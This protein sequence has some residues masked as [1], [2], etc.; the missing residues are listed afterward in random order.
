MH[1]CKRGAAAV[2]AVA[3]ISFALGAADPDASAA[4]AASGM[5]RA[6]HFSPDTPGV[7]IYLTPF[8]GGSSGLWLPNVGYGAVSDYRAVAA[9]L[10]VVAM[11]AH[12]AAASTPPIVSW[13][14]NVKSGKAYT[15]AAIGSNRALK[16]VVLNDDLS[17]PSGGT[18]RVRVIQAASRA[19]KADIGAASGQSI[20]RNVA[21]G[22][23]TGYVSL[24]AGTWILRA[25]A[26]GGSGFTASGQVSIA[27]GSVTSILLVDAP[28]GGIAVRSVLDAAGTGTVPV[29]AVPAGYGGTAAGHA[30]PRSASSGAVGALAIGL[31]ALLLVT[32]GTP[33]R[34]R[35]GRHHRA[36]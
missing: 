29:G 33:R 31:A 2:V 21:F 11:R 12:G 32:T 3:L 26:L 28:P 7:D 36:T 18:G 34:P 23:T 27:S 8:S 5:I 1:R 22:S 13:N 15:A 14:L 4:P 24:P 30:R 17:E 20:A 6:A 10:Y 25:R 35:R 9:G 16:T 19:P